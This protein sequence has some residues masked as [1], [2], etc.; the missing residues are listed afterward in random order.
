MFTTISS[1]SKV[2]IVHA[3][4]YLFLGTLVCTIGALP[5]GLVNLSVV[6]EAIKQ[7]GRE[8]MSIAFGA[9]L[10]EVLFALIALLAGTILA[11]YFNGNGLVKFIVLTVLIGSGIFFW[12][13]N[14]KFKNDNNSKVFNGFLKGILLNLM[15]LQVL[16][17]WIFAIAFLSVRNIRPSSFIQIILFISG[18][19][20]GKMVVLRA[21]SVFGKKIAEK[22]QL[23]SEIFSDKKEIETNIGFIQYDYLV[24]AMGADTNFFGQKK[25]QQNALSM[26]SASDAILIRNTI[27]ENFEKLFSNPKR[28]KLP[29]N[30]EN[31]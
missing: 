25:I 23:V 30:C 13:K 19:L 8:S 15:S 12:F 21:Y 1:E 14:G 31:G 28:K 17:F 29:K 27:L 22:S 5:F 10:I 2:M 24:L 7:N 4:T 26:K 18:V 3:I 9:S 11:S 16:L 20:I 6:D